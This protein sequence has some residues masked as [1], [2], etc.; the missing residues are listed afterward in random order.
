LSSYS[1]SGKYLPLALTAILALMGTQ[2][3]RH[4][5]TERDHAPAALAAA[6]LTDETGSAVRF[7]DFQGKA[8]VLNSFFASCPSVCP[9]Q[10]EALAAVQGLLSPAL[11]RRVRFLSLSVDPENDTPEV[12][13]AFALAHGADLSGW[14]FVRA[15][16]QTTTALTQ[17]LAVFTGPSEAQAAPAGHSTSVYLFDGSGR[18]VQRYAGSPL[19]I[20]RLAREIEQLDS[21]FQNQEPEL[22]EARR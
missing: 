18:L 10:T 19:D 16:A 5:Q 17:E 11:K 2:A 20:P 9:R 22:I 4:A 3:C 8:V 14:S 12:L 1:L 13:K 6:A 21:W 7:A 15:S